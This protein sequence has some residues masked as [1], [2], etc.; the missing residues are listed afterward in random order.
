MGALGAV[1]VAVFLAEG[2]PFMAVPLALLGG[3]VAGAA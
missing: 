1:T 3:V 2:S